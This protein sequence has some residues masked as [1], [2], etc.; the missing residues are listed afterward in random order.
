L[1][2]LLAP[3]EPDLRGTVDLLEV[4]VLVCR[5]GERQL[6]RPP[7][8]RGRRGLFWPGFVAS[9]PADHETVPPHEIAPML[10]WEAATLLL[11]RDRRNCF[12]ARLLWRPGHPRVED[13]ESLLAEKPGRA[14]SRGAEQSRTPLRLL[15]RRG[16]LSA[17]ARYAAR[18]GVANIRVPMNCPTA[19][20]GSPGQPLG[21]RIAEHLAGVVGAVR[22]LRLWLKRFHGVA[23][24]YLLR[25]WA[26]HRFLGRL[27]WADAARRLVESSAT[28]L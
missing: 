12:R 2:R 27:R 13:V 3:P 4:R 8:R 26:W 14:E 19:L 20:L 16:R 18:F 9:R 5:K 10:A 25:Y 23:T 15:S 1:E 21:A 6:R 11:A 24:K 28:P 17:Y 7:L 22:R